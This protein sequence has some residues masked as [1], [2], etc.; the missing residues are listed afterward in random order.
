MEIRV[1]ME[2]LLGLQKI[3]EVVFPI[4]LTNKT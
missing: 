2:K 3:A 4:L 1:L